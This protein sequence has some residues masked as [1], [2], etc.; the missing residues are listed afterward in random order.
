MAHPV[1]AIIDP[2]LQQHFHGHAHDGQRHASTSSSS[3]YQQ[4]HSQ[5][6]H[7]QQHQ[8]AAAGGTDAYSQ[9]RSATAAAT[10]GTG[11]GLPYNALH[12]AP[13]DD[14]ADDGESAGEEGSGHA[15]PDD[16]GNAG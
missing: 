7:A 13:Q 5:H 4:H 14:D 9:H 16:T 15:S 8:L 12:A 10:A 6:A 11:G 2:Q 1:N 3:L